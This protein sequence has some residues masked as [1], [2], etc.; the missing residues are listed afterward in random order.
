M[1]T[2]EE[3]DLIG[4]I[5]DF[6]LH[7]VEAML[8]EQERQ[9]NERDAKVFQED[10]SAGKEDGGF[11]WKTTEDGVDYWLDV[12]V[13]KKFDLLPKPTEQEANIE[14]ATATKVGGSHYKDMAIQPIEFILKNGL[15]FCEGNV[16]KYVCRY[17]AK[18]GRQDL[19]KAIHY[20]KL[21][22]EKEYE[23][24]TE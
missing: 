17:K 2:I 18:N 21:L 14:P 12:I 24:I 5:K 4:D 8:D 19:E 7:V 16:I 20:L 15:G 13:H 1:K 9:G 22:I 23:T 11:D 3:A 10:R 6:P